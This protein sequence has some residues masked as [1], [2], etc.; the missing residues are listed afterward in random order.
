[1]IDSLSPMPNFAV[2][3]KEQFAG[4]LH[5]IC[6]LRI[7]HALIG[8]VR[9]NDALKCEL[10]ACCGDQVCGAVGSGRTGFVAHELDLGAQGAKSGGD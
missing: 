10:R 7:F 6:P 4:G 9:V 3:I 2:A 5:A 8:F 1:M